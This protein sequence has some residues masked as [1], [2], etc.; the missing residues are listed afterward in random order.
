MPET[1]KSLRNLLRSKLGEHKFVV[2]SN[3][4]PYMHVYQQGRV[5]WIRPASGLTV[6]LDPLMQV[7]HGLWVAHGSGPADRD[8][9]DDKDFVEVPPDH[10]AYRLKR[11]WLTKE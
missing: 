9:C 2:V 1:P 4:E 10:P 5:E 11:V 8:V 6:A 3:R 7:S